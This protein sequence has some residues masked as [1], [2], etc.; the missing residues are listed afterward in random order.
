MHRYLRK[1]RSYKRRLDRSR[2]DRRAIFATSRDR[3]D[4]I[5]N[6]DKQR[7]GTRFVRRGR[8]EEETS[9][10]QREHRRGRPRGVEGPPFIYFGHASLSDVT[11]TEISRGKGGAARGACLLRG[12]GL[13]LSQ[14]RA[15][16]LDPAIPGATVVQ[17]TNVIRVGRRG[18]IAVPFVAVVA[19][20]AHLPLE[21]LS[22]AIPGNQSEFQRRQ[23]DSR[24]EKWDAPDFAH[25]RRCQPARSVQECVSGASRVS[26][27]GSS[28]T[29]NRGSSRVLGDLHQHPRIPEGE[30]RE[31][32][33]DRAAAVS[34]LQ[35]ERKRE[36]EKER[37]RKREREREKTLRKDARRRWPATA[38]DHLPTAMG[39]GWS[40]SPAH[41]H[42]A[43]D[44]QRSQRFQAKDRGSAGIH[45]SHLEGGW[46]APRGSTIR[47]S[48]GATISGYSGTGDLSSSLETMEDHREEIT[49][50]F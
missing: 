35:P 10:R 24:E 40:E 4:R 50:R 31:R 5:S 46:R 47:R 6:R 30:Y 48:S 33:L 7:R 20:R 42:R 34:R 21:G 49:S 39:Q 23:R 16:I 18:V 19:I 1:I 9:G 3:C 29:E 26:S 38:E 37:E 11:R 13:D 28:S 32:S 36:R 25:T 43:M 41:A 17:G 15:K 45:S 22:C 8:R 12:P 2:I 14:T 44:S 27:R